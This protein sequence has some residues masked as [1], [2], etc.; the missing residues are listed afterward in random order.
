[1][2]YVTVIECNA[3]MAETSLDVGVGPKRSILLMGH[4]YA[5]IRRRNIALMGKIASE[6]GPSPVS[7]TRIEVMPDA[8]P[9]DER[10]EILNG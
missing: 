8:T 3:K 1:M 10:D 9:E 7:R 2:P 5:R 6:I 4:P